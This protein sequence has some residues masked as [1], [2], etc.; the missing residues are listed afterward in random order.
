M[1]GTPCGRGTKTF[2]WK[3]LLP[4]PPSAREVTGAL[5]CCCDAGFSAAMS[6]TAS[7]GFPPPPLTPGKALPLGSSWVTLLRPP[8]LGAASLVPNDDE[9]GA[10]ATVT[11]SGGGGGGGAIDGGGAVTS[12][13]TAAV[14][15]VFVSATVIDG[16]EGAGFARHHQ[17]TGRDARGLAS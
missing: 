7:S 17:P 10:G 16:G 2:D 15:A 9:G 3:R 8:V 1:P 12:E 11:S 6:A 14:A 5:G 13:T 4:K